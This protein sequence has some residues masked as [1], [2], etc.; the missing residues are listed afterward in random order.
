[1]VLA[2]NY[3]FT[4]KLL[5]EFRFGFTWDTTGTANAFNGPGFAA[6]TGLTGLQNLFFNGL[7]ELDFK[8]LTSL[9]ADRLTETTQSRLF[10]YNDALTW[11]KGSHTMKFGGDIRNLAAITPLSF[12]GADNYGTFSYAQATTFTGQEFGDFLEGTPQTTSYDVVTADNDGVDTHYSFYAQDQ[13]KATQRLNISFGVRYDLQPGYHDVHGNIGNFNPAVPLSGEAVF[14]DGAES[15]LNAGFLASFNACP[16]G[17]TSGTAAANGAPCT[18]V[19]DN[20]QAGLSSSLR[21]TDKK[22]IMPRI[23]FA[24]RPF[25]DEKTAIRAGFAMYDITSLG[26]SFYSLT[27]T[28]Q[29]GTTIYSNGETATGPAYTWPAIFAGQGRSSNAAQLGTAYF[30]TANDINWK[31]PYSEQYTV[32]LDHEIANGY[33]ARISYIG[34]ETHDLV[35]APNLNDL[36]SMSST[37][38][39]DNQPLSARPFPNFG[40]INTRSTGANESYHSMQLDFNHHSSKGLTFDSTYTLAKNLA[41]NQGPDATSF[42]GEV[43]GSRA[44]WAYDR[45]IDFGQVYGTRRNRWNTTMVY[46]LPVGRGRQFGS[47]MNRLEDA[48]VGGWQLSNIFLWQSGPFLTPYFAGGEGDPSGTGSGLTANSSGGTYPGRAQHVDRVGPAKPANQSRTNWINK[49]SF[50]CPGYPGWTPGTNCTTGSGSGPVPLPIGR[51]GD[52][53]VCDIVGPGSVNLSSGLSKSFALTERLKLRT[54]G[55]FTNVL[56]HTNL[57]DPVL[58]ISKPTFGTITAARGSDFGGSRNGQVSVRL[59]F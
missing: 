49:A 23:G 42:S 47:K 18:P 35:W 40:V 45:T 57:A 6:S 27:G 15:N 9:N 20:T 22:R 21:A 36:P 13:W 28:L 3:S 34:M 39:A 5:N 8:Y 43:G 37:I 55:T 19:L 32:S 48:L 41:D 33:G 51:F 4:P 50:V 1:M 17:Q 59:E 12:Y 54:E 16:T 2:T 58:D 38:S 11:V 10:Q 30:G 31:D 29:S 26:S 53:Q 14:P 46:Q 52:S 56:N 7:S 24:F 25:N 44:S